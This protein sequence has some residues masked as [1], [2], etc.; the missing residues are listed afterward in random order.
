[1]AKEKATI[2]IDRAKL[3]EAREL[4]GARSTSAAVDIAIS[5]VIR[6]GRLRRDVDAYAAVPTTAEEAPLGRAQ[7]VWNDL[8]DETDWDAEWP[9]SE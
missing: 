3:A 6:R 9:E 8:H 5:E 4:L 7:P 2:T 1:M